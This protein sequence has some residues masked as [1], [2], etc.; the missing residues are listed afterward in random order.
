MAVPF[1]PAAR[2]RTADHRGA[3]DQYRQR[4]G[5]SSWHIF[6]FLAAPVMSAKTGSAVLL[7]FRMLFRTPC[8]PDYHDGIRFL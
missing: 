4:C 1:K 5:D 7:Q 2:V 6:E 8:R 3:Y